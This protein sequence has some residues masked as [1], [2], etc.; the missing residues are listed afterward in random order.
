MNASGSQRWL[1]QKV[2]LISLELVH[3]TDNRERDQCLMKV[4]TAL[5]NSMKR[6][7]DFVA[8]YGGEEFVVVLPN[9]DVEGALIV[10]ETLRANVDDLQIPHSLSIFKPNVTISLGVA[11]S[12]ANYADLPE[13]LIET[14]DKALYQA[15]KMEETATDLLTITRKLKRL[16]QSINHKHPDYV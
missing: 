10:A 14:S 1:S 9:T 11:I 12:F 8:R 15:K 5:K 16:F 6:N 13:T 2:A 4:A 7:G 3:A